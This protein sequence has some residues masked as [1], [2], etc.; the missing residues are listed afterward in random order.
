ML[1]RIVPK[2]A[3]CS[4]APIHFYKVAG[5][6]KSWRELS[7]DRHTLTADEDLRKVLENRPG[8]CY[9]VVR[10]QLLFTNWRELDH[11]SSRES[12]RST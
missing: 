12:L 6:V 5:N 9:S 11:F 4:P 8:R 2:D 10:T 7:V 3:T 1:Y